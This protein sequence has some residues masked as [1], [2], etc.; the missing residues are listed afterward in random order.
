MAL[1]RSGV[2]RRRLQLAR[3]QWLAVRGAVGEV[4][5]EQRVGRGIFA[6]QQRIELIEAGSS[7]TSTAS[8]LRSTSVSPGDSKTRAAAATY[9]SVAAHSNSGSSAQ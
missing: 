3:L 2:E 6:G 9:A 7:T 8:A 5:V 1:H 4:A